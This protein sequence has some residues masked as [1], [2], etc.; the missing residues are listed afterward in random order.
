MRA[1]ARRADPADMLSPLACDT[2]THAIL[3]AALDTRPIFTIDAGDRIASV[4]EAWL[5]FA[6]PWGDSA[7]T[8]DDVIG[9]PIWELTPGADVR[10]LWELLYG[11]VRSIGGQVFVPMRSDTPQERR[12]ID[13]ELRPLA[14]RAI[15]HIC[16]RIWTQARAPL[17][18]L[19]PARSRDERVLRCCAWCSRIEVRRGCWEEAED[20]QSLL[21]L[22]HDRTLPTLQAVAC[23]TCKQALLQT[24]PMAVGRPTAKPAKSGRKI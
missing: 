11:R 14:G 15:L 7:A 3:G 12:L 21:S 18:L 22:Q 5:E 13:I 2:C 20:A 10:Q 19:E 1:P 4:N 9:R 16:E 8:A 6:Q 23:V 24:F 17:A